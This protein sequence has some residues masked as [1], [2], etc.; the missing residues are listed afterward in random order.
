MV[1]SPLPTNGYPHIEII[2]AKEVRMEYDSAFEVAT[3]HIRFGPGA[4]REVGM[5]LTD[6]NVKRV[7]VLTDAVLSMLPP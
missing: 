2:P 3:S 6:L 4:T 5:D 7:M 1:E